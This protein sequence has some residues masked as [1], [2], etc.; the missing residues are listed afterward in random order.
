LSSSE[1][2]DSLADDDHDDGLAFGQQS[3]AV[4]DD[5][6][7]RNE[8]KGAVMQTS[9]VQKS[10]KINGE[11][12]TLQR[13]VNNRPELEHFRAFLADNF[14]GDDLN[15]WLDI[16]AVRHVTE[17]LR[18][19]SVTLVVRKY[20]NDDYFYGPTS[21]ANR[22]EQSKVCFSRSYCCSQYDRLLYCIVFFYFYIVLFILCVGYLLIVIIIIGVIIVSVCLFVTLYSG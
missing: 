20:F 4:S 8:A 7:A 2:V 21:P 12:F 11:E 18:A 9:G 10:A 1:I 6:S 17:R 16:E 15:C 22:Q 13:I 5:K 19:A 14:A 3:S